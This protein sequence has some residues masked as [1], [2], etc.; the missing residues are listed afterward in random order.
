L[1]E[2]SEYGYP[3][4]RFQKR[5]VKTELL[6]HWDSNLRI[7]VQQEIE[8]GEQF[9]YSSLLSGHFLENYQRSWGKSKGYQ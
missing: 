4:R 1:R 2:T 9:F 3:V 5:G 6:F 8:K 7:S